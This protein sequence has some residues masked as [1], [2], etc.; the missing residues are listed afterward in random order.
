MGDS[1]PA[2]VGQKNRMAGER[3]S[4]A[5]LW[6]DLWRP[7]QRLAAAEVARPHDGHD[8]RRTL[9]HDVAEALGP[10]DGLFQRLDLDHREAAHQLLGLD[11][12]AVGNAVLAAGELDAFGI[13]HE[14]PGGDQNA[15]LLRLLDQLAHLRHDLWGGRRGVLRHRV[16]AVQY[17]LHGDLSFGLGAGP[18]RLCGCAVTTDSR[19]TDARIDR[20]T[21]Q[22]ESWPGLR[23]EGGKPEI[24]GVMKVRA[25]SS[26]HQFLVMFQLQWYGRLC[27]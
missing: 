1:R 27:C 14:G 9:A 22:M 20:Q 13:G 24:D 19:L 11:E 26:H 2:E 10:G 16:W 23:E 6:A 3:S 25:P 15:G 7:G 12:R 8:L 18:G 5:I 21:R 17:E 4:P